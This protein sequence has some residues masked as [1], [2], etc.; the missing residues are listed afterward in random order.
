MKE[1]DF[2]NLKDVKRIVAVASG[3]GGVGKSTV[4][5][6]LVYRLKEKGF[7]TAIFD[8]DIYGPSQ[9]II[10]DIDNLQP[11]V[12][13]IGETEHF[14]PIEKNGVKIMSI[15]CMI[16]PSQPLIWRGPAAA[17][18][19]QQLLGQ[20][21]WQDLDVLVVDLPP[22]TGDI[23]LTLVQSLKI[24]GALIVTTPQRLSQSDVQKAVMMFKN[25]HISVPL[26]G[27]VENMSYFTPPQHPEEKYLI[28]GEG[29]G[30]YLADFFKTDLLCKAPIVEEG[31]IDKAKT[32]PLFQIN[33]SEFSEMT[34]KIIKKLNL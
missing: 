19:I 28:F 12:I 3:K 23:A 30:D 26:L 25:E 4:A 7:K 20:T 9:H 22:G 1:E 11:E 13:P 29:G 17:K 14:V 24:D 34:E 33:E 32:N 5:A 6:A 31:C 18:G 16:D 21:F 8:A 27:I 10:W 15:G 2:S